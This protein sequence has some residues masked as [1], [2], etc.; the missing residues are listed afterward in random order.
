[1]PSMGSVPKVDFLDKLNWLR[2][3]GADSYEFRTLY[4]AATYCSNPAKNG[5]VEW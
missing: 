4:R 5:V 3:A 2:T 1:M